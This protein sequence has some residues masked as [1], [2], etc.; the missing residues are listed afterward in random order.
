MKDVTYDPKGGLQG[1]QIF[2][3]IYQKVGWQML[4]LL[5]YHTFVCE[6]NCELE[7]GETVHCE[8]CAVSCET[9]S[10]RYIRSI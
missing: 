9:K 1:T 7:T 10:G 2:S 8:V 3:D 4:C 6:V 5:F